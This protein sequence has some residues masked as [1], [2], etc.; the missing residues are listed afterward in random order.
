[1]SD[2]WLILTAT[3]DIVVAVV[4]SAHVVL[5]KRDTRAAIGWVGLI[6]LAPL[7]GSFLYIWLGVNRI[8]RKARLLRSGHQRPEAAEH[9][10][11]CPQS[12]IDQTF[13]PGGVHL[14]SLVTLGSKVAKKPLLAGNRIQPLLDGD[15]AFPAMLQAIDE[16]TK[17]I[18]LSTY[19]FDNDPVGEN[20][21]IALKRAVDRNVQVRVLIDDM[22]SRYSWPTMVHAMQRAGIPCATFMPTLIPWKFQYTNL[23]THRKTL[24]VDGKVGF[25]GGINIREGHNLASNPKHPVRDIHFQVDGPVV[26]QFQETFADD[27]SFSTGE[28]L[29]GREWFPQIAE[30]GSVLARGVPDGPDENFESFRHLLLGAIACAESSIRVVTPYFLPDASLIIGLNVA[31]MRGIT[32]DIVLP[33]ENNILPVQWAS[34]SHLS[35]LV[36]RGCRIWISPPPFDHTK[37]MVIDDLISFVGSSNWDPRSLRLN[38]EFNLECYDRELATQL[39]SIVQERIEKARPFT[40][41]DLTE[42]NLAIRLRDGIAALASPYL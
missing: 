21:L 2:E 41:T 38:F 18:S 37:L 22:G 24:V 17:T 27:W 30:Q 11:M 1:M 7:I 8:E 13:G 23:R 34:M 29:Q 26:S 19:I 39:T 36:D 25:T 3:I 10:Q 14:L 40:V 12:V 33:G 35:Q 4:V 15:Q 6:W 16:A 31:A 5:T 9:R 42:R 32:V 28:V 20:F